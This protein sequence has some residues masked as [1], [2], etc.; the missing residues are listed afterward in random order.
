MGQVEEAVKAPIKSGVLSPTT[1]PTNTTNY[2]QQ[3]QDTLQMMKDYTATMTKSVKKLDSDVRKSVTEQ[4]DLNQKY[5]K[6]LELYSEHY[7]DC[8]K[9]NLEE[10]GDYK[11]VLDQCIQVNERVSK[12]ELKLNVVKEVVGLSLD[13]NNYSTRLQQMKSPSFNSLSKRIQENENENLEIKR[14]IDSIDSIIDKKVN[15][16]INHKI[17]KKFEEKLNSYKFVKKSELASQIDKQITSHNL[18]TETEFREV[19]D[20]LTDFVRDSTEREKVLKV[21]LSMMYNEET[22]EFKLVRKT[23]FEKLHSTYLKSTVENEK[24][25]LKVDQCKEEIDEYKKEINCYKADIENYKKKTDEYI[26]ETETYKLENNK[27][28]D[29]NVQYMK[30]IDKFKKDFEQSKNIEIFQKLISRSKNFKKVDI[31]IEPLDD[32]DLN[33][34]I[35]NATISSDGGKLSNGVKPGKK[36]PLKRTPLKKSNINTNKQANGKSL[37]L[38]G[39]LDNISAGDDISPPSSSGINDVYPFTDDK[40]QAKLRFQKT[41]EDIKRYIPKIRLTLSEDELK[42]CNQ[43]PTPNTIYHFVKTLT[44]DSTIDDKLKSIERLQTQLLF[45]NTS[46]SEWPKELYRFTEEYFNEVDQLP[47]D[48]D[49]NLWGK[50]IVFIFSQHDIPA[51]VTE[52]CYPLYN[53]VPTPTISTREWAYELIRTFSR[54]VCD[55]K[56]LLYL[57]YHINRHLRA[58]N[59]IYDQREYDAINNYIVLSQFLLTKVKENYI[60]W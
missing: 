14:K 19:A 37:T 5:A 27:F 33:G 30:E 57:K 11:K 42:Q 40:G 58:A 17:N 26:S 50:S 13:V 60:V 28:K 46:F 20:K 43:P 22:E 24:Y 49:L 4:K 6:S 47:V 25:K 56:D 59:L 15:E 23:D 44:F 8:S 29:E 54:Y 45:K 53:K 10:S 2:E 39:S 3:F 21:I 9:R 55:P 12:T 7:L 48:L 34:S 51:E 1:V 36:E 31:P 32:I 18:I 41:Y 38:N 16:I 35:E 52:R